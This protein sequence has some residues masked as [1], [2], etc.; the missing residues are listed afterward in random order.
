MKTL[1]LG[2][3]VREVHMTPSISTDVCMAWTTA[4]TCCRIL[5]SPWELSKL[6]GIQPAEVQ[7]NISPTAVA[8]EAKTQLI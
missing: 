8:T 7:N 4:W 6:E 1:P 2:F 5:S 3:V